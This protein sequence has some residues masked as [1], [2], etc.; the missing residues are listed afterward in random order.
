MLTGALDWSRLILLEDAKSQ[1]DTAF[2][3]TQHRGYAFENAFGGATS[4]LRRS[5]SKDLSGVDLAITGVPFDQAVTHRT[6]TRFGPRAIREASSLMPYDPPYGWPTNPLEELGIID[7]GDVGPSA[8]AYDPVNLP[9]YPSGFNAVE[10]VDGYAAL[11][12]LRRALPALSAFEVMWNEFYRLVTTPPAT[13]VPRMRPTAGSAPFADPSVA[14][15]RV[16]AR[17]S[18]IQAMGRPAAVALSRLM[19][20]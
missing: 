14:S 17:Q 5:Y 20:R 13:P 3:R 2:T 18:L 6:G 12:D 15:E 4:F 9:T 16:R 1:V 8:A 10:M 11:R 19:R 7:Y